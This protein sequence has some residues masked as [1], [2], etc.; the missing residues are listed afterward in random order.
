MVGAIVEQF[1]GRYLA[2]GGQF[3]KMA[4]GGGPRRVYEFPPAAAT[5][6][7]M[8]AEGSQGKVPTTLESVYAALQR[9]GT[10]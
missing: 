4:G 8:Y 6:E 2:L 7:I 9:S 10:R 5:L 3:E 1:G